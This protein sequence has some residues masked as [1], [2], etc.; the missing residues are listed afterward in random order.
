METETIKEDAKRAL[1]A[2][3]NKSLQIE[4]EFIMNYPRMIDKLVNYDEIHD[5]QLTRDIQ[6][7]SKD[8]LRHF[9]E[10]TALVEKLGGQPMWNMEMIARLDD[11][12]EL[13]TRQLGKER[14]VLSIFEQAKRIVEQN[15]VKVKAGGLFRRLI[16]GLKDEP[17][18]RI[19]Y[20]PEI[21]SIVEREIMEEKG[22]VRLVEDSIA[23][24]KALKKK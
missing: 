12:E 20:V 14:E 11:V 21:M 10:L 18:E 19:I 22:H 7:F 23:T 4:Y 9:G 16:I 17:P 5:E 8:S 13:L 2:L 6:K 1:V 24:I 3:I 15:S